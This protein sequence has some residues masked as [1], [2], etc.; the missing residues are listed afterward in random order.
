MPVACLVARTAHRKELRGQVVAIKPWDPILQPDG[1]P[2][3]AK[4]QWPDYVHI[5]ISDASIEGAG[6]LTEGWDQQF[7][8]EEV[9]VQGRRRRL[10]LTVNANLATREPRARIDRADLKGFLADNR[11]ATVVSESA[12]EMVIDVDDAHLAGDV[13]ADLMDVREN[14]E[15]RR[16]VINEVQ[17][18]IAE[19]AAGEATITLA[20]ARSA[21]TDRSL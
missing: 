9:R 19:A 2:W 15:P 3:G 16:Y 8:I 4:E 14:F 7:A 11:G 13:L 6:F 17:L 21:A 18:A 5:L 12:A 20:Q 10:R 1:P